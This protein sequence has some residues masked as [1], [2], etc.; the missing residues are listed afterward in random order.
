MSS[1]RHT[2][3]DEHNCLAS[4]RL[5]SE[6]ELASP[7]S[8]VLQSTIRPPQ[9]THKLSIISCFCYDDGCILQQRRHT[10]DTCDKYNNAIGHHHILLR[11]SWNEI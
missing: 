9:E 5:S 11:I 2:Q 7:Q 8:T 4:E 10:T 6:I 1:K 3:P